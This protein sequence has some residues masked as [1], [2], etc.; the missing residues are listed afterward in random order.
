MRIAPRN[1]SRLSSSLAGTFL[2][3]LASKDTTGQ[4]TPPVA[5]VLIVVGARPAISV[6]F[7]V[8]CPQ[9][10]LLRSALD[11][12][13]SRVTVLVILIHTARAIEDTGL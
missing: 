6:L 8:T 11:T 3:R 7:G 10:R 1:Q 2:E 4:I 5:R 12:L 9:E 13:T